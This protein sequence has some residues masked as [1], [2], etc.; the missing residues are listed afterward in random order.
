[1]STEPKYK[2]KILL[3]LLALVGLLSLAVIVVPP[4]ITL[5]SLKPTI[6][7]TIFSKTGIKAKIH[8]DVNFSLMGKAS[9]VAHNVSIPNGTVSS[10]E[11]HF[12]LIEIFNI[13]RANISGDIQVNGANI[14]I[15]KLIPFVSKNDVLV[16]DSKITFLN[17]EYYI[18]NGNFS[19]ENIDVLVRTDQHK[20]E[21]KSTNNKFVIKNKNNDLI[22]TGELLKDGGARG[23]IS[24]I[25]QDV[26]RWFN[27]HTPR[28][29]GRFPIN[30]NFTWDGGYGV[31]FTDISANGIYGSIEFKDDGYRIVK[32]KSNNINYDMS[33][34]M[35]D[36][37]ILQNASFDLDFYGDMTFMKQRINYLK[38]DTVCVDNK[39][40]INNITADNIHIFGG[41]VDKDGAHDVNVAGPLSGLHTTCLFN[42]TPKSWSC[43][44]F[45]HGNNITSVF[46]VTND[47][48]NADVYSTE[49]YED[50][51][52]FVVTIRKLASSGEVRFYYPDMAGTLHLRKNDYTVDY[53]HLDNKSLNQ[54]KINPK[55]LP[56]FMKDES[57]D[58]VWISG[59]MIFTPNSKQWQLSK[60]SDFFILRGE[61]FKQLTRKLDLQSF[62]NLPYVLSGNY[63]NGNISDFTVEIAGHKLTGMLFGKSITLKTDVLNITPFINQS[64]LEKFEELSFFTN[65]PIL[66]PFESNI[67]V[68]LSANRIIYKDAEYN[69]FVYSLRDN[70]QTFSISDSNRGN[71][72]ATIN[73]DNTKYNTNIQLNKFMFNEKIL[74]ENMPLNISDTAI[75]AEIKLKTYGKIAHDIISN[76]SGTFDVSFDGGK[77]YGLGLAE[78]YASAPKLTILSG[79]YAL[80]KALTGGITPVKK[81]HIVGTYKNGDIKTDEPFTLSMPHTDATGILQIENNEMIAKLKLILRGA[82]TDPEPIDL[83]IYPNDSRD[84]SLSE[85]ML[86]FDPEYMREFVKIHNQF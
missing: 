53:T 28:I 55:F 65:H 76:L 71:L 30:A 9:I 23:H 80:Y 81:M 51:K 14:Y 12:P 18:I 15:E 35:Q 49:I 44:E 25:A 16:N 31:S 13:K 46:S 43:K 21:I 74:P 33:F 7:N 19:K 37:M 66:L 17:K 26:N 83:I 47:V 4:Q 86:H 75:T 50:M 52:P 70:I 78:F 1:M 77:L 54:A 63:K 39:I 56:E 8:G 27:F 84:F 48:I 34:F 64:F 85:I 11:F 5:N 24:I 20:Y 59:T 82:S 41:Y 60:S 72:L 22:L 3:F 2:N 68:A 57:G 32:L 61:N 36:P 79:E 29:V 45:S 42:G 40:I 67:N 58:F 6:E 38:L 10:I 69:N 73:K 62:N